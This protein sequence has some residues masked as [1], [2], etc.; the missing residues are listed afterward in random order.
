MVVII[1]LILVAAALFS[2]RVEQMGRLNISA[3]VLALTLLYVI[4][5][6][7]IYFTNFGLNR[8]MVNTTKRQRDGRTWCSFA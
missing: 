5:G 3:I 1:L 2:T 6:F 7:T 4:V 8:G